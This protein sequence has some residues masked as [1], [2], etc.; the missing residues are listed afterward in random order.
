MYFSIINLVFDNKHED[1]IVNKKFIFYE[2]R[3]KMYNNIIDDLSILT[4]N[5]K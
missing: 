5:N 3:F 2:F 1:F 4:K